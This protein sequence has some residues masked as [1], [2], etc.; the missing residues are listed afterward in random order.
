MN[1]A[2]AIFSIILDPNETLAMGIN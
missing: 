2:A 1:W